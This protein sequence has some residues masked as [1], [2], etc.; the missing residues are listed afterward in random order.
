MSAIVMKNFIGRKYA[1]GVV[2]GLCSMALAL[3]LLAFV[4]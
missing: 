4:V 2:V 3:G 1:P